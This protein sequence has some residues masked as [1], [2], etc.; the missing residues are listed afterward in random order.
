MEPIRNLD[1]II[2]RVGDLPAIPE[3][4]AEVLRA[5]DDPLVD[6]ADV[7]EIIERDPAMT[8][9]ILRI[10]NS[11]YYGMKQYVGTLKLALVI[12]GVREVRNIVLGVSVF[13]T[14][15]DGKHNKLIPDSFW[16]H[17]FLVGGLSKQLATTMRLGMHGEAFICGLLHDMGKLVLLRQMSTPYAKLLESARERPETLCEAEVSQYGFTHADAAAALAER[18]NFPKTLADAI[19]LHHPAR[20]T[21][22]STAKDP[23]LAAIVR[24][25]NVA[26]H[27]DLDEAGGPSAATSDSEIWTVLSASPAPIDAADRRKVLA[28][29]IEELKGNPTPQF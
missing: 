11:P 26:V 19:H 24:L 14:L 4:V 25:A 9:K 29:M 16:N 1:Q 18:W 3:V 2:E 13:D 15:K 20:D 17:S 28:V 5:T 23:K 7:T 10:S 22:L 27:E 21:A 12:L 8:A 6:M